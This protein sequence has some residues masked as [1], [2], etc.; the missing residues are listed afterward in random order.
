MSNII[1]IIIINMYYYGGAITKYTAGPPY[2]VKSHNHKLAYTA[3]QQVRWW[4]RACQL[5]GNDD[6]NRT[7]LSLELIIL[8]N[9]I[10]NVS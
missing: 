6:L 1:I 3:W 8:Y 2:S 9:N 5:T 10:N 4:G 7:V